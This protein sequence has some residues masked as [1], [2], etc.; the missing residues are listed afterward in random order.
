M[1]T[2]TRREEK[3]ARRAAA[4]GAGPTGEDAIARFPGAKAGFA[5]F[6]EVLMI[7]TLITLLSIPLI[8][9]PAAL[10][11]GIRHLRRYLHGEDSRL[12][13]FWADMRTGILPG[14][15]V[16]VV[17]LV[18]TAILLLD[19][20]LANS[21]A[22]PGGPVI[23]AVGW[24]GLA[25]VGVTLLAAAAAWTPERGWRA[26]VTVVPAVLIGD[27]RGAMYL[28]ATVVFVVV[29]TW[30]LPPLII[31]GLGCAAMAAVAIP[32]RPGRRRAS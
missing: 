6:G 31:A 3:A 20:D 24:V 22:L 29:V 2:L 14:L 1:P 5:L 10:A 15:V 19:I 26:A 28:V 7:G 8:T 11:A 21:G 25:A 32:E 17:G 16:G 23:A 13:F 4:S 12:A 27:L 18:L 9:L 30:A